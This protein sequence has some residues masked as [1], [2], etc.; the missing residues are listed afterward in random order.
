LASEFNN[1][2][3]TNSD[4]ML[5]NP[6]HVA[7]LR[8]VFRAANGAGMAI[9]VHMRSSVTLERPHGAAQARAFL[10]EVLPSAPDVT[11]QLAHMAGAGSSH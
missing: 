1:D 10:D 6:A 2:G 5:D 9:V 4:V 8:E 11:V 3:C 7:K